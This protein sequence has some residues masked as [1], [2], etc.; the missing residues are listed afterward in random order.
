MFVDN[1][2][3]FSLIFRLAIAYHKPYNLLSNGSKPSHNKQLSDGLDH[4]APQITP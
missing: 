3:G 2:S 1:D 4:P